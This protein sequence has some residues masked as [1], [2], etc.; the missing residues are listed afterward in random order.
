MA[1]S[2][3]TIRLHVLTRRLETECTECLFSSMAK[4]STVQLLETGVKTWFEKTVC[5]RCEDMKA[6]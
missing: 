1:K 2:S 3:L 4:I 6:R 5:V